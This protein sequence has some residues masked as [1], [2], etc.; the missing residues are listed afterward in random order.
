MQQGELQS[1][2]VVEDEADIRKIIK[3]SLENVGGFEVEMCASAHEALEVL[4]NRNP[5]L[6]LLDVMMPVMDGPTLLKE[7]KQNTNSKDIPVIFLTAKVQSHEV[8]EYMDMGVIGVI[9]K[10]FDPVEL[11]EKIKHLWQTMSPA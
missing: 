10:P 9:S 5:D 3:V 11:P 2:L 4:P 8:E 1:I 7:I 6:I